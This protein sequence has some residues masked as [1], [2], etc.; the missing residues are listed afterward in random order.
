MD[1]NTEAII[2]LA[3]ARLLHLE[4][5]ALMDRGD[6]V[7]ARTVRVDP[8]AETV[9]F[10]RVFEHGV[11]TGP[12]WA[13]GRAADL[14]AD[15]LA[16]HRSLLQ[17]TADHGSRLL[18]EATL[19]YADAYV[20]HPDLDA[21]VVTDD[22]AAVTDLEAACPPDDVSEVDLAEMAQRWV[23]LDEADTPLAGAG[24]AVWTQILA[25]LGVLTA[26]PLRRRGN[27]TLVA[28][29]ATNEALDSGLIPQWRARFDNDASR[30]VAD[31][32][33]YRQVGSQTTVFIDH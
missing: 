15:E 7:P 33:G 28:A 32:L 2:R 20:Q 27:G 21:A 5:A 11:L 24:Y 3:W 23:L 25:H 19:A 22:V 1:E 30:R 10:V 31:R 26:H 9:S 6:A 8:D 13:V 14:S 4:D 16:S 18:G 12:Q 29:L 17:L